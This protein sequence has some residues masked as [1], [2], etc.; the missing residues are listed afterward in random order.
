MLL[1]PL[2]AVCFKKGCSSSFGVR[3]SDDAV[4]ARS[5]FLGAYDM[6]AAIVT[7]KHNH[8]KRNKYLRTCF[9]PQNADML[10]LNRPIERKQMKRHLRNDDLAK[11]APISAERHVSAI[12][13]K[14]R[15]A[16]HLQTL[17]C[18][19]T[20]HQTDWSEFPQT[21]HNN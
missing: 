20:F 7:S 9:L 13:N 16:R 1:P 10:Q 5:T 8:T 14:D 6:T 15:L 4:V 21:A 17:C 18:D 3:T 12:D 19:Q 2:M 11:R